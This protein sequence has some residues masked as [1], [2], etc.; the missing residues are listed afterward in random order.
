MHSHNVESTYTHIMHIIILYPHTYV[1]VHTRVR[2]TYCTTMVFPAFHVQLLVTVVA[3]LDIPV[4]MINVSRPKIIKIHS[5][6][7][8]GCSLHICYRTFR[9]VNCMFGH[10]VFLQVCFMPWC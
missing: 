6:R 5:I 8:G 10:L 1:L 4:A 9:V 2:T 7:D 3:S